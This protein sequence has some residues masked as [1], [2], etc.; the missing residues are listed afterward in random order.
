MIGRAFSDLA[1]FYMLVFSIEDLIG[2]QNVER[3]SIGWLRASRNLFATWAAGLRSS[4]AWWRDLLILVLVVDAALGLVAFSIFFLGWLE[5]DWAKALY[6]ALVV[7]PATVIV[8]F[9]ISAGSEVFLHAADQA[10]EPPLEIRTA[11]RLV[12]REVA[13]W[14]QVG[15]LVGNRPSRTASEALGSR[16]LVALLVGA[17]AITVI[18][19]AAILIRGLAYVVGLSVW[20]VL[21]GPA[22]ILSAIA[23]RTGADNILNVGKYL[24][25]VFGALARFL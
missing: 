9:L 8:P 7:L 3:F 13:V 14:K 12:R 1:L 18:S 21:F 25:L 19:L 11:A 6:L 10:S 4:V 2:Q 17:V 15:H 23:Q 24:L 22:T 16:F 20:L 5:Q